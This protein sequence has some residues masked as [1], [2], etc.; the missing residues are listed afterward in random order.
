M[1]LAQDPKPG[2]EVFDGETVK[3]VVSKMPTTTTTTTS[4]SLEAE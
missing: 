3:I 1:V 4:S 2:E